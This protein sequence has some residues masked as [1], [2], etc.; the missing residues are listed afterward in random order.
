MTKDIEIEVG[1]YVMY[2]YPATFEDKFPH[3]KMTIEKVTD[4]GIENF[5][6][7][8]PIILKK[9]RIIKILKNGKPIDY[10]G[11]DSMRITKEDN[12]EGKNGNSRGTTK[13]N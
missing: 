3:V 12:E 8:E 13:R 7:D 10:Y 1:D 11:Y 4:V 5:R 6:T 2:Q 9:H